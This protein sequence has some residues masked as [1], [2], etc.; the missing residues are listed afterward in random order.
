MDFNSFIHKIIKSSET[1]KSSTLLAAFFLNLYVFTK[2]LIYY[3]LLIHI[4]F[5]LVFCKRSCN[6]IK[7]FTH[8][9]TQTLNPFLVD[10]RPHLRAFEHITVLKIHFHNR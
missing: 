2:L 8:F 5:P 7:L 10:R 3:F 6:F 4:I 9:L 1:K